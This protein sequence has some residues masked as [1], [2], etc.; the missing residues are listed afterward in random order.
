MADN[1][2]RA[3]TYMMKHEFALVLPDLDQAIRIRPDYDRVIQLGAQQTSVCGHRL[4]AQHHGWNLG[5]ISGVIFLIFT[6]ACV[7]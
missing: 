2:N 5:T 1:E 6:Y 4:L 3:Y 7:K